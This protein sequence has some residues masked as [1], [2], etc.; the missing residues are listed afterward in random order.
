MAGTASLK[1]SMTCYSTVV[2]ELEKVLLQ[3]VE[4]AASIRKHGIKGEILRKT[5]NKIVM[6]ERPKQ[7]L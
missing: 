4:W 1:W 7:S 5:S 2:V 6:R 3:S